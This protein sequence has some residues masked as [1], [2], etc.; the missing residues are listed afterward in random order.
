M[1]ERPRGFAVDTARD[2]SDC[3]VLIV[4]DEKT[5]RFTLGEA[6]RDQ[7]FRAYEA[8][9]GAEAMAQLRTQGVDVVL[10]DFMLKE[11]GEDGLV[12]LKAL[13]RDF[14]EVEVVMLTAHASYDLAVRAVKEGCYHFI[15]KPFQNDHVK[16]VVQAAL[17]SAR[18]RREMEVLRRE[19]RA[20]SGGLREVLETVRRIAPS[21][22]TVLLTG[23]TG[24]GKEVI[25]HAVHRF[26]DA[27]SGPF[28]AV[29]CSAVPE[30]LLESELFGYEKGAF[31]D[32][33]A[34]KKGV[35]E[36]AHGGTLFLDEIGDMAAGLQAKLLRVLETGTFK[37]LGGT[38]DIGV[39]V[40]V[41]A[42]TNRDLKALVAAKRFRD[43]LYYRLAVVPIAI[44]PLRERRED[45]LPLAAFFLEHV[46][47]ELGRAFRGFAAEAERALCT[48]PW[49]GNVRELRNVVERAALLSSAETI[50]PEALPREV[51]SPDPAWERP[52]PPERGFW[53]LA[54]AERLAIEAALHR[55]E[56][57]KTRA[58]EALGISRQTLRSKV[59]E[60]GLAELAGGDG[61]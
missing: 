52:A 19:S 31:T 27:A 30:N 15:A 5:L 6:L 46:G 38:G 3:G 35:F 47:R 49:P 2:A 45:V 34:R 7:G 28:V 39:R 11:S 50:P 22:A 36:L 55:F 23:E 24:S 59:K 21:R 20:R 12:I 51:L 40:R 9:N 8:A 26:S 14:P 43:D 18:L 1:N 58:A 4:D 41:V 56:G 61:D 42:A 17:E 32:A 13:R 60:Y 57:N 16:M 53:T 25:A 10:L 37:R 44:P 29:N 54:E 33:Q 48:Y